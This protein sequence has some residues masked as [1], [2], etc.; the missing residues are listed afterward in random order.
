MQS[1]IFRQYSPAD[2]LRSDR[3]AGDRQRH[4]QK[5]RESIR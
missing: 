2:S 5:V 4:R 1:S 3:G